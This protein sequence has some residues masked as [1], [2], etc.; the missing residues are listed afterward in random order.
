MTPVAVPGHLSSTFRA[1]AAACERLGSTMYAQLL[2]A[3]ADD[4]D[5]GGVVRDVLRGYENDPGPS[6]LA[7]RLAGGLHRLV[8]TGAAPALERFYPSTGGA[9]Q[10]E[11][12]WPAV[13]HVLDEHRDGLRESLALSPQ[14]NEVGRSAALLG[15]LLHIAYQVGAPLPVRLWEIGSSA[16]LNLRADRYR[17]EYPGGAWGPEDSPLV[18]RDAWRGRPPPLEAPLSIAERTGSDRS[19]ID[20]STPDGRAALDAYVW[21]DQVRR[22]AR[23][24]A[25][26]RVAA[27]V[28]AVVLRRGASEV[29][30]DIEPA[31]GRTTVLWHS[32]MWQYLDRYEQ[33]DIAGAVEALGRR[34]RRDAP[35]AHLS[36][37][38]T[39]RTPDREH[40]FLVV[41]RLWPRAATWSPGERR[42]LA[43]AAPHGLP[44]TWEER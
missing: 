29:V 1:Q 34:A 24:R 4:I 3:M 17:Y 38:P 22:R 30:A 15:G 28:P 40:E 36:M 23:L 2:A 37:E 33:H 11:R 31:E 44:T 13:R 10:Q 8:L 42:I 21:P 16:G 20:A 18:L 43:V 14:T 25:A 35:F 19:P 7:L 27:E 5:A 26:L 32:V 9:W 6:G 39:R 41:A 12:G